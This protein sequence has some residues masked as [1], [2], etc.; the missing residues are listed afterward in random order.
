MKKKYSI[1]AVDKYYVEKQKR[2]RTARS[3]RWMQCK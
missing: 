2:K 3:S 1:L